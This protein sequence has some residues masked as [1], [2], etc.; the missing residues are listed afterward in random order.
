MLDRLLLPLLSRPLAAMARALHRQRI[1]ADTV[2]LSAFACG[3]LAAL[4]ISQH[5]FLSGLALILLSRLLDGLDGT[6]ARLTTPTDRGA[7]LD[8]SLDFLFYSSIPFAFALAAPESNALAGAA[9]IF[10]FVGTGTSFLAFAVMA[11]KRRI[12]STTYPNKGFYYLGGLTE[13]SET[14]AC[15]ALMCI[16]PA[17]FPLLA[18]GFAALCA[19]TTFS[20]LA[21][22]WHSFTGSES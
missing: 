3:L 4:A 18:W 11:E 16:F 7:F 19:L 12:H 13:A 2:T 1:H 14:L 17:Y 15:F 8:I 22:G 10:A 5:W 9:L 20:R 21:A 6:L